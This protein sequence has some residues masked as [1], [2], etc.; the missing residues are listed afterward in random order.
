MTDSPIIAD[1][2]GRRGPPADRQ[3]VATAPIR[4]WRHP[5]LSPPGQ[6]QRTIGRGTVRSE[7]M[8]VMHILPHRRRQVLCANPSCGGETRNPRF[9]SR[10]CAATVNNRGKQRNPR[11]DHP[12][13]RCAT[14]QAPPNR[15][16]CSRCWK[17][18]AAENTQR[19]LSSVHSAASYQ[20]SATIRR[21]ARRVYA[22]SGKQQMCAICGYDRHIEVCRIRAINS[23]PLDTPIAVINDP[24]N[25]VALCPNH[26]WE[27]DRQLVSVQGLEP[28]FSA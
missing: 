22:E 10:S 18:I 6:R 13:P 28:R 9:C 26:H 27:F 2:W 1:G 17:E 14:A 23:W 25:L 8:H 24:V 12:C 16:Y 4:G 15:K 19:N 5:V 11:R 21:H 7:E 20:R 3:P